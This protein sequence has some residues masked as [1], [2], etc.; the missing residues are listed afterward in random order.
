MDN[1]YMKQ[2]C[3]RHGVDFSELLE[4]VRSGLKGHDI[5]HFTDGELEVIRESLEIAG[6]V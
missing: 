4:K 3:E 2:C 1:Y 6:E 5:P